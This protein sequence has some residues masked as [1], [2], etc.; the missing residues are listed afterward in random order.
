VL[1]FAINFAAVYYAGL[2]YLHQATALPFSRINFNA[3]KYH[4]VTDG[5][6]LPMMLYGITAGIKLSKKWF[7]RQR[8]NE[9]LPKQKLATELQLLK[10]S[11]HPRFLFHALHTVEKYI[12]NASPTSP[13]LIVQLSDLLS[14]ILY[15]KDE[16]W[17]TLEKEL[18][19]IGCYINL[20]EKG[21]EKAAIS[22]L[23]LQEM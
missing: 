2:L 7:L 12:E 10:T 19:I 6:F 20:E 15:E 13:A 18:E 9:R 16:R 4:A 3:N 17:V 22:T 1:L 5:L 8:E 21:F 14:Y 11:I 23:N